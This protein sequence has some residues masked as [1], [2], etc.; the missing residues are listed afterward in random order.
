MTSASFGTRERYYARTLPI[1]WDISRTDGRI[2][3][4]Y[5]LNDHNFISDPMIA[6]Y[7]ISN[8]RFLEHYINELPYKAILF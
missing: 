6:K 4:N 8:R 2:R 5:F 1:I 7:L 3:T